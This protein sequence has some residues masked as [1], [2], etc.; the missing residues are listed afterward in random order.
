MTGLVADRLFVQFVIERLK[1]LL[2]GD[3]DSSGNVKIYCCRED[4]STKEHIGAVAIRI[5]DEG[6]FDWIAGYA[7]LLPEDILEV[8]RVLCH[9]SDRHRGVQ[10][11]D[12]R[13]EIILRI[14]DRGETWVHEHRWGDG[15]DDEVPE[16][17]KQDIVSYAYKLFGGQGS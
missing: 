10:D 7:E 1:V 6:L 3:N 15:L 8:D 4:I 2:E 13:H 17:V 9:L 12:R 16:H 14:A 5:P 11:R